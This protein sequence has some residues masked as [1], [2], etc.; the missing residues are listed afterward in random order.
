MLTRL[1]IK[2]IA[3]ID[4]VDIEF[5]NGFNVLTGETGAGKSIV[6]DSINMVL[7]ERTS[8][9]LIRNGEKKAIVE[10]MFDI[11]SQKV[12]ESLNELG[13]E[14]ED[15]SLLIYRD[16]N[17]DGKGSCR[18]NGQIA[19]TG[20]VKE[21]ARLLI[22]IHGQNDNQ[23]LLMPSKHIEFL[24]S[25]AGN[26][27]LLNE[28][29]SLYLELKQIEKKM[30][31]CEIDE[32][33][34][35]RKIDLLQFQIDEI[36]SAK[37]T[38]GEEEALIERREFVG[39][40]SKII[41]ALENARALLYDGDN[42]SK[43]VHDA[44]A[45]V[46][47]GFAE[48]SK[49][50]SKLNEFYEALNSIAIELDDI[51]Y[52]TRDYAENIEYDQK[53]LDDIELRL[54][55]IHKLKRKYGNSIESILEYNEK[56]QNELDQIIKSDELY[57]KLE[58]DY[59]Q[60]VDKLKEIAEKLNKSRVSAA[61]T[62]EGKIMSELSDLDMTKVKF[63]VDIRPVGLTHSG[64]DEVEFLISTNP[65][66]PLKPLSK[67][68]SGGEMSRIMLAIKSILADSDDVETLIFDEIDTGVSGRAA[69]KIAE[70]ISKISTKKQILCITHLAQIASMADSH[71]LIEKTVKEDKTS[72]VVSE[73]D[74]EMRQKE[75]A[76]IIGG[77]FITDLTMQ[78]AREMLD[79]ANTLKKECVV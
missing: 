15:G 23:A 11:S 53:E 22:N 56:I 60:T 54:D 14:A 55:L 21:I 19:T 6:I 26:S 1:H 76:R 52:Q 31:E 28:Y 63:K 70:K 77:A 20:M 3:V 71:F 58:N 79:M 24:D 78:N 45:E 13:I 32:Q 61:A 59:R 49:Y 9:D 29:H 4:E 48:I 73:M 7:G 16:I 75:L 18:I 36:T 69:Q 41:A 8:K 64:S 33:E 57:Q 62:L 47:D 25:Y 46:I 67:I 74:E 10:A 68:A 35:E 44:L 43:S 37:L 65:G 42:Y 51:I 38:K 72:T 27:N 50:D 17:V 12:I 30:K 2:N 39:S 40:A 66:E 34:K 5:K